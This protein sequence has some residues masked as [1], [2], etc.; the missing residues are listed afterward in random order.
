MSTISIMLD[1]DVDGTFH[2]PVPPELRGRRVR[3]TMQAEGSTANKIPDGEKMFAALEQ[4]AARGGVQEIPDPLAW[5]R[6]Q[7]EDRVLDGRA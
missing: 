7:R 5:E 2:V 6:E 1:A 4:L 3:V